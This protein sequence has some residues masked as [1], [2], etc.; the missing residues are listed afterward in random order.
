MERNLSVGVTA[1]RL[2]QDLGTKHD[3]NGPSAQPHQA[4]QLSANRV[5]EVGDVFLY[6]ACRNE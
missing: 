3:S 6:G 4:F 1:I 5:R 2:Q